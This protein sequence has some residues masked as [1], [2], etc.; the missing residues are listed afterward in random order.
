MDF[1]VLEHKNPVTAW[2]LARSHEKKI[3][4]KSESMGRQSKRKRSEFDV[5]AAFRVLAEGTAK[6]ILIAACAY[7]VFAGYR[8]VT[9]S[10]HFMVNQVTWVGHQRLSTEELASQIGPVAGKNIFQLD[11]GEVS[12][13][14]VEHPWVK[15]ASVRRIFPQGLHIDL[16]ERTP[17][18]RIQLDRIYVMDNYGILLGPEEKEFHGLPLITGISV[19][20]P[21]PGHN[22]ASEEMIGGLKTMYYFNRLPMFEE[23]PIDTVRIGN[24][25]RITFLTRNRKMEI[26]VRPETVAESFKNLM[27]VLGTIGEDERALSYI[28]LS[29]KNKVVVKHRKETGKI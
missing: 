19:D 25:S 15:T 21:K 28:D 2:K 3:R 18:A 13:K 10:P 4:K 7:G 24:H 5:G 26:Y 1:A 12:R 8:F 22:V 20:H 14:L 11:L 9:D 6:A 29:F 17:F 27:L 16:K 23:N